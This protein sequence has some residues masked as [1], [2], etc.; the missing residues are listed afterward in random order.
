MGFHSG[1]TALALNRFGLGGRPK[2]LAFAR[3]DPRGFFADEVKRKL[4]VQ[5]TVFDLLDTPAALAALREQR[6]VRREARARTVP[7]TNNDDMTGGAMRELAK[8]P[9]EPP[10]PQRLYRAEVR[11]RL[12]AASV[13]Q[14]GYIE[15]LVWFWANHFAVSA[16]KGGPVRATAGAFEREAIRPHVLGRFS[17]MLLAVETHPTMLFYLDNQLSIGPGS[18]AG[19]RRGRG[20]NENLAREILDL[21]TVGVGGGYAQKDVTNLAKVL[22]GWTIAGPEGRLGP[23]GTFAFNPNWH[24]PGDHVVLGRRYGQAGPEQGRAALLDLARQPATAKHVAF[25]LARHFVRDEPPPEL[26]AKLANV[27]RDSDGDLAAVSLALLHADE[28]WDA[29]ATKIRSP[30]EFLVASLRL[31]SLRSDNPVPFI[32]ALVAL[33]QPL[34]APPGPNGFPDTVAHWASP[35]GIK[36]RLDIAARIAERAP[37]SQPVELLEA[38]FGPIASRETREAVARAES[39]SQGVALLLMSPEFQRR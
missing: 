4:V 11:A 21:H 19:R 28:A 24:E 17:D 26:V 10:V 1:L 2:D 29:E 25:K 22:T 7:N 13:I 32:G 30:Q 5:P 6:Q 14:A 38:E 31:L 8:Q 34:W 3:S 33:G 18:V 15:R 27:F 37:V 20:L 9:A 12:A 35:E 16:A 23:P 36:T 39:R